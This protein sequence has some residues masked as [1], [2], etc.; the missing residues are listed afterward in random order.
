MHMLAW[1]YPAEQVTRSWTV[2][3][4][5][6]KAVELSS[7]DEEECDCSNQVV[8]ELFS[9]DQETDCDCSIYSNTAITPA[10]NSLLQQGGWPSDKVTIYSYA[11]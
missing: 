4:L 11:S 5:D 3:C 7:G 1:F 6:G 8:D 10:D 9:G 2:H